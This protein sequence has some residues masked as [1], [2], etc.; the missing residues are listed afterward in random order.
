MN[1]EK[2]FSIGKTAKMLGVSI[3]VLNEVKDQALG[4]ERINKGN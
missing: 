2:L 4:E 1:S 3:E